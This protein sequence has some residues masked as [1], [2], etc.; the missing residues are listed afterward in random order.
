MLAGANQAHD[1]FPS[2]ISEWR[3]IMLNTTTS[4][5]Q[6]STESAAAGLAPK[7]RTTW[8]GWKR[9]AI[10]PAPSFAGCHGSSALRSSQQKRGCTDVASAVA[11]V[12][13]FVSEWLVQHGAEAK[14]SASLRKHA[15]DIGNATRQM[16]RLASGDPVRHIRHRR[17]FPL[18]SEVPGF[19]EYLRSECGLMESTIQGYRLQQIKRRQRRR[20]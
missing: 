14:T 17:P 20:S 2:D 12:E 16:L 13:E 6:R 18:E 4:N 1:Y 8:D 3:N 15:I 19:Q 9:T 7:L 10:L 11:L 5:L